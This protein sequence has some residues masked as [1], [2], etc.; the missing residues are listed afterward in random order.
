LIEQAQAEGQ[1][2]LSMKK[3]RQSLKTPKGPFSK[4]FWLHLCK[5]IYSSNGEK[6]ELDSDM[7]NPV[8]LYNWL[9]ALHTQQQEIPL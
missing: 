4:W 3:V 1:T 7:I 2:E 5:R 8:L 9:A 6:Y